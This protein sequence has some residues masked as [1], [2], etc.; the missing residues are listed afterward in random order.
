MTTGTSTSGRRPRTRTGTRSRRRTGGE[1]LTGGGDQDFDDLIFTIN[2]TPAAGS[3][4]SVGGR[5]TEKGGG[6]HGVAR[7]TGDDYQPLF[8]GVAGGDGLSDVSR[9]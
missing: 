8:Y 9:G 5:V 4:A 1:D 2:G 6:A 7:D 3:G